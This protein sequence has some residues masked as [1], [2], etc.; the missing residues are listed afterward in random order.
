MLLVRDIDE[1]LTMDGPALR[2]GAVAFQGGRVVWTG[3]S[4]AAPDADEVL[5]GSGCIGLPGL[6]DCHTHALFAGSR[7]REFQ[8]RLAG[9]DYST[10][11]EEGG[12][13]L[14]TVR[15][16]REATDEELAE[17][18][19]ARLQDFLEQGVTTV[20]VKTGYALSTE[21]ELRCLRLMEQRS[22]PTRVLR[23]FLG[24]HTVPAEWRP[25]RAGYVRHLVEEMLPVVAEHAQF[26]D[27]YCDRGAFTLEMAR[28]VL[29][30]GMARGLKGRIHAEQVEH[31]GSASLAAELGCTSADH[32]ERIS[33]EGIEAMAAAGTVAVLL[34]GARL[35]LRDP[36]PP[37]EAMREAGVPL[38]V[39]TDFNPGTSPVRSL[40]GAATLAC[41]DMGL[42]VDEA[43]LGVTRNAGAALGR[44]DLGW[45]GPG[46][47]G[48]MALFSP[49][50]GEPRDA[51]VLV[52]YLGGHRAAAVVRNGRVVWS[53]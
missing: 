37:V 9:E 31:T 7:A 2:G 48:D 46:S 21:H 50:P 18:L 11:L 47:A 15:A 29:S 10:I 19:E 20:E 8:R 16:T 24:A 34:P 30:A 14:G 6:V 36:A 52:Q 3:P 33:V 5:D 41:V 42:S 32:L 53:S 35:Y 12:G 22:W 51:A 25:D 45:L 1:L 4:A 28:T 49:P 39:A 26:I 27:V 13:I 38:A 17:S 44:E 43:L 40:L 23:T